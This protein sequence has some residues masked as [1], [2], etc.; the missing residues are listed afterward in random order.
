MSDLLRS[1]ENVWFRGRQLVVHDQRCCSEFRL[2]S[3]YE[4]EIGVHVACT[5]CCSTAPTDAS[6]ASVVRLAG[7]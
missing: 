3:A 2:V 6:E 4:K 7:A 5:F 1:V